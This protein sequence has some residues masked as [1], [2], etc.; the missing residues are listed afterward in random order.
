LRVG[1]GESTVTIRADF[2][3]LKLLDAVDKAVNETRPLFR[4]HT[5]A[6]ARP[7]AHRDPPPSAFHVSERR[8]PR[9]HQ[10]RENSESGEDLPRAGT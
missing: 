8:S 5:P 4:H 3:A 7:R 2:T 1:H 6:A 10:T 9:R